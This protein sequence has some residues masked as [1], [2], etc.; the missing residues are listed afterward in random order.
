MHA[1]I[2]D[3]GKLLI[4]GRM[5]ELV[6]RFSQVDVRL[7]RDPT[8]LAGVRILEREGDRAR[9]LVDHAEARQPL[10]DSG[11]EVINDVPMTLEELFLALVQK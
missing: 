11:V 10:A 7:A 6:G 9:L 3:N 2:I 4:A 5:D 8:G 1:A